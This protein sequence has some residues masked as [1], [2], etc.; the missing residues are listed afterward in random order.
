MAID[1]RCFGR[2][3]APDT[4]DRLY[5][6]R[7]VASRRRWRYWQQTWSGDQMDTPECVGYAW[8]HWLSAAPICQWLDP[9]GIY[10]AAQLVD[11]WAGQDYDGTSVR[12]G[13][14][15]LESLGVITSYHWAFNV[16]AMVSQV[17]EVG[18]VVFGSNWYE[19]MC[20][21]DDRGMISVA[22]EIY[23]G[24][25]Y[26][27]DGVTVDR[28]VFRL[29]NSWG[30]AWGLNGRAWIRFSDLRRLLD[31]DGECCNAIERRAVPP[32]E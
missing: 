32:S 2:F 13:A 12:A 9:T 27:I 5:A 11:E 6:L 14:K 24:H 7:P 23:G 20:Y 31:E 30:R 1:Y 21:P 26:L 25:A 8:S 10:R 18:P 29:Q 4:R 15:I 19:M 3:Y 16:A 17:L 28:Q 22:G